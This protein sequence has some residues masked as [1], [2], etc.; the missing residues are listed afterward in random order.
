MFLSHQFFSKASDFQFSLPE[1]T[2][3]LGGLFS[4]VT[5]LIKM[6]EPPEVKSHHYEV[7]DLNPG[8]LSTVLSFVLLYCHVI[9]LFSTN[10]HVLNNVSLHYEPICKTS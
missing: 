5:Q 7:E 4:P 8:L 3:P 9:H 10:V 6:T 1:V 2:C